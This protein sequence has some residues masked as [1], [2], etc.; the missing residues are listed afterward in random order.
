VTQ[1]Q[2][3]DDV[4][5]L[6]RQAGVDHWLFGG[7]AVDFHIGEITREHGDVDLA[8][9]LDDMPRIEE[10]L[11][12]DG[13]VDQRDP[14]A[15]G[16]K[17]FARDGVRLELTYLYRGEAGEIYTPLLDG[18]RGTWTR[19]ALA[20]DVLELGG[21]RCRVIAREPLMRMKRRL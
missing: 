10:I 9:W 17:A 19:E 12:A 4:A 15:D 5:G 16:G 21:V 7:W 1:L 14:D 3:L 6:L 13:W 8:V 20:D 2:A 11:V 18:S